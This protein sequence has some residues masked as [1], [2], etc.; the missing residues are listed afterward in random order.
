MG[1]WC[2]KE[3]KFVSVS[4]GNGK[5][6]KIRAAGDATLE[7]VW[8]FIKSAV[9]FGIFAVIEDPDGTKKQFLKGVD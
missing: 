3:P 8:R 4:L 2:E 6:W 5:K 1:D 7:D 9:P